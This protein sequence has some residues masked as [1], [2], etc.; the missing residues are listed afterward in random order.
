MSGRKAFLSRKAPA[1]VG[2]SNGNI[3]FSADLAERVLFVDGC[4][5]A[6]CVG[7]AREPN[8]SKAATREFW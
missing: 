8:D 6:A 3:M 1:G 5:K 7:A 4:P 2:A